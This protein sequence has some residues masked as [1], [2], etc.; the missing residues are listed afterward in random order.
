MSNSGVSFIGCND[1]KC[2]VTVLLSE[3]SASFLLAMLASTSSQAHD[4]QS[5]TV[6]SFEPEAPNWNTVPFGLDTVDIAEHQ[7]SNALPKLNPQN[8]IPG[9]NPL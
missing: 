8:P 9:P 2:T 5:T 1:I 4:G 6:E 7:P 3:I